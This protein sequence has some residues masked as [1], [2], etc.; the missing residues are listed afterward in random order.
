MERASAFSIHIG[1]ILHGLNDLLLLYSWKRPQRCSCNSRSHSRIDYI[2]IQN[3]IRFLGH[4]LQVQRYIPF[5]L[6]FLWSF[7]FVS[8]FLVMLNMFFIRSNGLSIVIA[9]AFS[10]LY[11]FYL[12]VDTQLI[13]G[14][15]RNEL[16]LDNYILG[17]MLLYIDIIQL[18]LNLLRILGQ[19]NW[20]CEVI[21][22][23]TIINSM[24]FP[25]LNYILT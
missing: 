2:C 13:M 19:R 18:F 3:K 16:T 6:G 14:G 21:V 22:V 24:L 7:I 1:R 12:I 15:R 17:A 8:M 9:I 20:H 10:A 23:F 4:L 5:Y 11:A 25:I